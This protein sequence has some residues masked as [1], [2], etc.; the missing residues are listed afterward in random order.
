MKVVRLSALRTGC[1]YPR[2]VFLVLISVRGLVNSRTIVQPEGLYQC[3]VPMTQSGIEPA[4]FRLAPQFL[5]LSATVCPISTVSTKVFRQNF[6]KSTITKEDVP[7]FGECECVHSR[8]PVCVV[9]LC[10]PT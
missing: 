4:T 3:K 7:N 10:V 9:I 1:L 5:N 2:E 8:L 6:K